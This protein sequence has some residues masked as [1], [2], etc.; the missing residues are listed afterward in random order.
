MKIFL[1]VILSC[2]PALA[3][4]AVYIAA[5]SAGGN[6]GVDCADAKA[7]SYFN[8]AGSWSATPTGIQIGPDTTAHLCGTFT[9]SAAAD[10]YIQFQA[11]GSSG[12]PVILLWE[13]GA[14]VQAPYFSAAHGAVDLNGK[15]FLTLDGGTNGVL[16]NTANGSSLA[17]QQASALIQ[18]SNSSNITVQNL[19]I[20]PVYVHVSSPNDP[21]GSGAYGINLQGGSNET[22]QNNTITQCDVCILMAWHNGNSNWTISGNTITNANQHIEMGGLD[23]T[24]TTISVHNNEC[25]GWANWD[26][27]GDNY[28]H[29][30]LH[31]F[32]IGAGVTGAVPLSFYS[33]YSHGDA[34][35]HGTALLAFIENNGGGTT[36]TWNIF[37]NVA[38]STNAANNPGN[39]L[40]YT[41]AG[42]CGIYNNT[43]QTATSSSASIGVDLASSGCSIQNN[44]FNI[45]W[46][47]VYLESAQTLSTTNKNDYHTVGNWDYQGSIV[48]SLASWKTAC[49]CDAAAVITDPLLNG[50]FGLQS[51]SA[52]IS[53]GANLTSLSIAPL[54][55]DKAGIA[56]PSSTAWDSGAYQFQS[57]APAGAVCSGPCGVFR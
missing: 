44:I 51:G 57:A 6:T 12:H 11:S 22:I 45:I 32:A 23:G 28:H 18:S 50:T 26:D 48:S 16:K 10:S 53:L 55:S 42:S 36:G 38:S 5:T 39:G 47:S 29:N 31:Y 30:C 35:V 15:S 3:T 19:S 24:V 7:L 54:D 46:V 56:R 40:I 2:F 52:A 27:T 9:A 1:L 34:G 20:G 43:F 41:Q 4:N 33:N 37:N 49:S 13:S 14:V 8:T 25:S 17:N 21:N